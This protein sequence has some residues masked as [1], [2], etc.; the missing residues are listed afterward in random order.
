MR[1][2]HLEFTPTPRTARRLIKMMD[3]PRTFEK[4]P[5]EQIAEILSR[6][7][8]M[9]LREFTLADLQ[10]GDELL[11][12]AEEKPAVVAEGENNLIRWWVIRSGANTY[13]VRRFENFC[14]CSCPDHFFNKAVCKHI[15]LTTVHY[16]PRCQ[17]VEND[18]ALTSMCEGC[19]A[20]EAPYLKPADP[21][22]EKV[23][24]FRI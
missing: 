15:S 20:D 22:P 4:T 24:N 11:Q 16:C 18:P 5:D 17:K 1:P 19:K 7:S 21:K 13:E 14:F 8:V 10:R 3:E 2:R 12:E 9:D 6:Y 23:G